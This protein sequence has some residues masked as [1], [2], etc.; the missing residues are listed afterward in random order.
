MTPRRLLTA[1]VVTLSAG[2]T[3]TT[4][5]LDANRPPPTALVT[6][7]AGAAS[8]CV[9]PDCRRVTGR[10]GWDSNHEAVD[11]L[12]VGPLG[13]A[14]GGPR[15]RGCNVGPRQYMRG[16]ACLPSRC[17]VIAGEDPLREDP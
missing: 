9:I 10:L 15:W 13:E 6:R 12:G 7:D 5:A 4:A 17:T 2:A 8:A 16:A 11:C 14:D 1:A 3:V